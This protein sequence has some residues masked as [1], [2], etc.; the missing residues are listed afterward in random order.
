VNE[1]GKEVRIVRIQSE[2]TGTKTKSFLT[3][4]SYIANFLFYLD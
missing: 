3:S 4:W 2:Q 1:G